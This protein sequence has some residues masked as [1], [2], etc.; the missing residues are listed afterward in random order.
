LVHVNTLIDR[1]R[2]LVTC[3]GQYVN[4]RGYMLL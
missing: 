3:T 2:W 4:I 1:I